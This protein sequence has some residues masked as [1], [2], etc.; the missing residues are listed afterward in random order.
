[1]QGNHIPRAR[2]GATE[3]DAEKTLSRAEISLDGP[4][5]NLPPL[6][7][8]ELRIIGRCVT[9]VGDTVVD[10]QH[11]PLHYEGM[12]G[13]V[14]KDTVMML[15]V[16]RFT[17]EDFL[18]HQE[19]LKAEKEKE[20]LE[21]NDG[22]SQR[23]CGEATGGTH[24]GNE[25]GPCD[26][27]LLESGNVLENTGPAPAS[28]PLTCRQIR[29]LGSGSLGPVPFMTISRRRIRNVVFGRD[30]PSTFYS[31]FQDPSRAAFD[32]QCLRM[33]VRRYLVHT[34]QGNSPSK[35]LRTFIQWRCNYNNTDDELLIRV[36]REELAF[37][38]RTEKDMKSVERFANSRSLLRTY[39]PAD[40]IFRETGIL[41]LTRIPVQTFCLAVLELLVTVLLLSF[42]AYSFATAEALI[43]YGYVKDYAS[44]VT[45]SCIVSLLA[46]GASAVHS[47]R[48][49][50]PLNFNAYGVVRL[51]FVTISIGL[52]TMV[53]VMVGE[54]VS[55][56]H[57]RKYLQ[58][59]VTT[60]NE[61][62][63]YY[64]IHGCRGFGELCTPNNTYPLCMQST[65]N[66]SAVFPCTQELS[67]G[68]IR[69]LIPIVVFSIVLIALFIIDQFLHYRL[70]QVSRMLMSHL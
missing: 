27:A 18:K 1:M 36:A 45:A 56:A 3:H 24:S 39:R 62:C 21:K 59:L 12:V 51:V 40:G 60:S 9:F 15:N 68:M 63:Y 20:S 10:G 69:V 34:S 66:V 67:S 49:R 47:L 29:R 43:V 32:M 50:L 26:C 52:N 28:A 53:L 44:P 57:M 16:R 70:V 2:E 25:T 61:L 46:S 4:C 48:M 41:F 38:V 13:M 64:T 55:F 35:S 23:R 22:G 33:F 8:Q 17:P 6:R 54:A 65:C 31:L 14:T 58:R 42:S 37:L 11:V 30:P 5:T 19:S 7:P